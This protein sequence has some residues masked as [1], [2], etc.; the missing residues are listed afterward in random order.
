MTVQI[1]LS[2]REENSEG[3]IEHGDEENVGNSEEG[4]KMRNEQTAL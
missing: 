2:W 1:G 4:S 3:A